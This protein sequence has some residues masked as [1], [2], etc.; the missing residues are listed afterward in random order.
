MTRQTNK[1]KYTFLV[2][3]IIGITSSCSNNVKLQS[4]IDAVNNLH[5][6]KTYA[7]QGETIWAVGQWALYKTRST[8]REEIF[9]LIN[10]GPVNGFRRIA[11]TGKSGTS[12]WLEQHIVEPGHEQHIAALVT[13]MNH[14]EEKQL[15]IT[16]LKFSQANGE[17]VEIEEQELASSEAEDARAKMQ[18]LLYLLSHSQNKGRSRNITVPAGTFYNVNELPISL[19]LW[20]GLVKGT[21]M[22]SQAVPILSVVNLQVI[23]D[24]SGWFKDT[25][26]W[27]LADFGQTGKSS[28]FSVKE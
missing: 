2:L 16:K 14:Q 9:R 7:N 13:G 22:Y 6:D 19:S 25:S 26:T 15:K 4:E 10:T 12:F 23:N 20:L 24:T 18:Y 27:E 11:I 8:S 5:P 3:L 17:I 1:K 28:Y 21:V